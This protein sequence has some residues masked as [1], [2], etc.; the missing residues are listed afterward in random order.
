V[1]VLAFGLL[2]GVLSRVEEVTDGLSLGISSDSAWCAA[3]FAAG[4]A[5]R[6]AL[7]LTAAN[8]GY[9]AWI[10]VLQPELP[11]AAAA[12]PVEAWL[13]LGLAAGVVFGVT[14]GAWRRGAGLPVA[15]PLALVLVLEGGDALRGGPLTHAPGLLAGVALAVA[16]AGSARV[17]VGT[18][19]L[20]IAVAVTGVGAAWLP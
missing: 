18:A 17:A 10:A 13:G 12:G 9:Y 11:L 4:S 16:S 8:A 3:A 6:G 1:L 19:A 5:R 7:L 14:G 20:L 2:L 15:V